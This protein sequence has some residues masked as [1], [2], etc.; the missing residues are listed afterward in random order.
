MTIVQLQ[1]FQAICRYNS[2]TLA[3]EAMHVTQPSLS[4]ALRE[5][6][7]EFGVRLFLRQ[8]N[9]LQLTREGELFLEQA[10][11]ILKRVENTSQLMHSLSGADQP[12]RVGVP[13]IIS[14]FLVP[15]I[16]AGLRKKHPRSIVHLF[17]YGT[18]ALKEMVRND[19]LDAAFVLLSEPAESDLNVLPLLTTSVVFCVLDTHPLAGFDVLDYEQLRDQPLILHCPDS[20]QNMMLIKRLNRLG[21]EPWVW[22]HSSQLFTIQQFILQGEAGACLLKEAAE[23]VRDTCQPQTGIR[24]IPFRDA[25]PA[26]IALIWK[27]GR[28][29]STTAINFLDYMQQYPLSR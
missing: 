12:A 22:V 23:L 28:H 29:F 15:R 6:E 16:F 17:E 19:S 21:I 27:K 4:S 20:Y 1:Y 3:A 2:M 25:L 26:P 8:N 9:R 7:T 5:L 18:M 10:E 14:T 13:P 24:L 11:I